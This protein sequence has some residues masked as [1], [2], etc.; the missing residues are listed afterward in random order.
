MQSVESVREWAPPSHFDQFTLVRPL[1]RGGMGQVFLGRDD[2]LERRVALKFISA[3]QPSA[4]LRE[5]FVSEARAIARLSHPNV[6][7]VYRIGDVDGRPY[8]AYEFVDGESLDR[9]ATPVSW[10][11]A[12][13]LSVGLARGLEAAHAH[14]IVHRDVKPGNVMLSL[15]GE[16]KLLDFGLAKVI[17]ESSP[18][19]PAVIVQA[20]S[21]TR[22]GDVASTTAGAPTDPAGSAFTR[23][24]TIMGTPAYMAP[25]LWCGEPANAR[26]DVFALGLVIYEMLA[27][28]LP[29]ASGDREAIARAILETDLPPIRRVR[30]EVPESFANIVDRC[31]RRDAT[32][33]FPDAEPVRLALEDLQKVFL[34]TSG[35]VDAMQIEPDRVLVAQSMVRV[36]GNLS[37]LVSTLYDRLFTHDPSLRALFP[38]D[39]AD[40]QQKLGHMLQVAIDGLGD[41]A[42][43]QPVLEDLGRRHLRYGVRAT[44]FDALERSLIEALAELDRDAWSTELDRSWRR[45]FAFIES[46]MRKGMVAE[47]A[48]VASNEI[49]PI[50]VRARRDDASNEVPPKTR[51]ARTRD[52]VSIAYQTLG[53]GT[54]D[55]VVLLGWITHVEMAWH[56]PSPSSFLR[57]LSRFGRVVVFDKRGTGMSD[58][59]FE[60]TSIDR[61]LDDLRAVLDTVGCRRPILV[62]CCDDAATAAVFAATEPDRVRGLVLYGGSARVVE[63]ND[64]PHG[65]PQSFVD[66]VLGQIREH[67]GEPLFVEQEA[68]SMAHDAEFC[69]WLA[70]YM[71]MAASPGNAEAI[72]KAN[73]S[74]DI[75]AL[76]PSI[77][78][79]T[80]VLH[81]SDDRKTKVACGRDLAARIARALFVELGGAD[82]LPYV[83]DTATLLARVD[84]F[85]SLLTR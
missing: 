62:G 38:A 36:R 78:A 12:L 7:G 72:S 14:G 21:S 13:R 56:H 35:A 41:P 46:A 70:F 29:Y 48:T 58:R 57:G 75:R 37:T 32:E 16:V 39:L 49:P 27:G 61:R 42:R 64:F 51:Y 1:G 63:A 31:V 43:L 4:S 47:N 82:H 18:P 50:P 80:L 23:P 5:R 53:E 10:E 11:T 33:R 3:S 20:P 59:A 54:T 17:D 45:A 85:V 79:P 26:S 25:E 24:G 9:I 66:D 40:Q 30:P 52:D 68:P 34:P 2:A 44:H 8:I 67:W 74:S 15:K 65:Q 84:A 77:V 19:S 55:I 73:A 69:R 6:V 71:R 76:L 28:A 83:G 60:S 81:R 22:S